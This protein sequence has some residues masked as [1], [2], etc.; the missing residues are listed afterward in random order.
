[1]EGV[2]I[3]FGDI[4]TLYLYPK[5]PIR[6]RWEIELVRCFEQLEAGCT[7]FA[8]SEYLEVITVPVNW[9]DLFHHTYGAPISQP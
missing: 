9:V 1:M 3:V 4:H 8:T 2:L 6:V 7:A 5:H